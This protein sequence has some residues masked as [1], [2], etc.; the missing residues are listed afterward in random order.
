MNPEK[1]ELLVRR[2]CRREN[3][4]ARA[5]AEAKAKLALALAVLALLLG[6]LAVLPN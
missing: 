5:H 6:L 3:Y 4:E 1:A 2:V